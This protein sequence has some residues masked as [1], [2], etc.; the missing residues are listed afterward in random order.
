MSVATLCDQ[1]LAVE[2]S[3]VLDSCLQGMDLRFELDNDVAL[4]SP[5]ARSM[6][7]RIESMGLLETEDVRR[8]GIAFQESLLN[9]MHH[10]NLELHSD[11]RQDE[12]SLYYDLAAARRVMWPYCDR[13][14]RVLVSLSR[15]RVKF[16]IR[17]E[18]LGFELQS[19]SDPTTKENLSR[20]GGRGLLMIRTFMDEVSHNDCGNC[21]T[22][23]KYSSRGH[24]QL[25]RLN[26]QDDLVLSPDILLFECLGL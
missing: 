6:M 12:E 26:E 10:G 18:G 20:I 3:P 8:V 7:W 21:I 11:L 24:E 17:D 16:V 23:I 5:L 19:V 13:K 15:E 22:L 25:A 4:V 1:L 14:V 2:E 9:T